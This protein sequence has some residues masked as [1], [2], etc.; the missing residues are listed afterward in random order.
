[1]FPCFGKIAN[2]GNLKAL[3]SYGVPCMYS[4]VDMVDPKKVRKLM[5]SGVFSF[6]VKDLI[7]YFKEFEKS[8]SGIE[9]RVYTI[10]KEHSEYEPDKTVQ[11]IVRQIAPVYQRRLRKQQ[12]PIFE[13]LS[14]TAKGL[15][16]SIRYK[17]R[18]FMHETD[19]KLHDKPVIVP[20]S[21]QE[22]KYKLEKIRNNL[23]QGRE[24]KP[25]RVVN[26]MLLEA[27][28]LHNNT[29]SKTVGA[30]K[31]ILS[32]LDL[33]LRRSV[34][35]DNEELNDLLKTSNDRLDNKKIKIPFSRKAFIYD[36]DNLIKNLPDKVLQ[37]K[38]YNIAAKLPT[39]S[40]STSAFIAKMA[41]KTSDE[42]VY[43]L[44]FPFFASVE[45]ILPKSCGGKDEMAN[46]GGA[47]SRE[48]TLRQNIEFTRQMKRQPLTRINCQKYLDR[49]IEF[50]KNG[51]F[52][53]HNVSPKYIDD[54]KHTIQ[55]QS[56]GQLVLDTSGLNGR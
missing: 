28:R 29:N 44:L 49:M 20:F 23:A 41:T 32:F 3:F 56:K 39:S 27:E 33:I 51:L 5:K 9:Q 42:I 30:Q 55:L 21:T 18:Q 2:A 15:P 45:H 52:K 48:N 31:R 16:D 12:A 34:L 43:R 47:C 1:M 24:T 4:G 50:V 11:E 53:K 46:F 54:F 35:N 40:Q 7:P 10:I 14:E 6:P 13:E 36:L 37:E 19:D 22:F 26:K 38:L 8:L 25:V 17:F